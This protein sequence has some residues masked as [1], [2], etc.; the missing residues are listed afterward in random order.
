MARHSGPTLRAHRHRA[1]HTIDLD[2]SAEDLVAR[3]ASRWGI[4]QAFAD[5]RQI[6]GIGEARN[7]IRRAVQR[8]APF[9]LICFSIWVALNAPGARR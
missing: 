7:R 4:E 5:A 6:I 1:D 8:A 3:Y 2:S 9:G